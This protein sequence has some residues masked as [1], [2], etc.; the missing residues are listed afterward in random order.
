MIPIGIPQDSQT[1]SSGFPYEFH[2]IPQEFSIEKLALALGMISSKNV[3]ICHFWGR[4]KKLLTT[5]TRSNSKFTSLRSAYGLA[6]LAQKSLP[7]LLQNG[8]LPTRQKS[9]WFTIRNVQLGKS[10]MVLFWVRQLSI[11][12]LSKQLIRQLYI[13]P[14]YWDTGIPQESHRNPTGI[15]QDSTGFHRIPTGFPQNSYRI[16][17]AFP[18]EFHRSSKR[19]LQ[20]SH[21]NSTGIPKYS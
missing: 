12:Q 14:K 4:L 9:K 10:P 2:R 8:H 17:T 11:S 7:V 18:Q 13:S 15:P 19:F 20:N 5:L 3:D 21:R 6:P 16:S 1:N